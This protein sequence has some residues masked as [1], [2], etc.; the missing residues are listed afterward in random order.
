MWDYYSSPDSIEIFSDWYWTYG[1]AK[2]KKKKG[3]RCGLR[4]EFSTTKEKE[5]AF[6]TLRPVRTGSFS[7]SNC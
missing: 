7:G 1:K 5:K 2:K 4:K 6:C 3:G